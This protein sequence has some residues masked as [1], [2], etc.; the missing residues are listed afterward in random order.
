[1]TDMQEIIQKHLKGKDGIGSEVLDALY[2]TIEQYSDQQVVKHNLP[3]AYVD[4]IIGKVLIDVALIMIG[5]SCGLKFEQ[6]KVLAHQILFLI[7]QTV[8]ESQ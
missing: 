7:N 3:K 6:A 2:S 4:V 1:M 5:P 8:K